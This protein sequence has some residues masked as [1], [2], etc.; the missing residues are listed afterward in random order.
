MGPCISTLWKK[1]PLSDLKR[2]EK[3]KSVE[4]GNQDYSV[5][6][7][8]DNGPGRRKARKKIADADSESSS[9]SNSPCDI[10]PSSKSP[11]GRKAQRS[12]KT[13]KE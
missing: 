3:R 5:P 13:L 7:S 4:E 9:D 1:Q 6:S 11:R 10:E 12:Q 8:G 2:E